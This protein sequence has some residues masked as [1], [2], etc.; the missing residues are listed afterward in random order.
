M[1]RKKFW[2]N[3]PVLPNNVNLSGRKTFISFS[4]QSA[5]KFYGLIIWKKSNAWNP[6]EFPHV[7]LT[8]HKIRSLSSALASGQPVM[9]W[10]P[11]WGKTWATGL[12]LATPTTLKR[13]PHLRWSW[14]IS[15]SLQLNCSRSQLPDLQKNKSA[16]WQ[17]SNFTMKNSLSSNSWY[18]AYIIF[19]YRFTDRSFKIRFN[20]YL[21]RLSSFMVDDSAEIL[22]RFAIGNPSRN[23]KTK[24]SIFT[25]F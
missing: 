22:E 4:E 8:D 20:V 21:S 5:L 9:A 3:F 17:V 10:G 2:F 7:N 18:S 24:Q 23:E 11:W 15:A 19:F 1:N 12:I 6:W 25:I 16:P 13:S 14:I